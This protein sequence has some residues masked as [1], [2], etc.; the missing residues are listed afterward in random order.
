MTTPGNGAPAVI[1][2][3]GVSGSGKTTIAALLAGMLHWQFADGDDFHPAANVQ[4]MKSGLPLTDEDRLPWLRAIAS[5]IA[6]KRESG[7]HGVIACSALKRRYRAMLSGGRDDVRLVYL[8]GD[9]ELIAHRMAARH[10]HFMPVALLDSQLATL[11]EP[12]AD[13]HALVVSI[14]A[15]PEEIAGHII[16]ELRLGQTALR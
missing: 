4:K 8:R 3:M 15:R 6:Q 16:T 1:V 13:E 11:E 10:E 12:D 9:S 5:W 2:V 7:G 14:A